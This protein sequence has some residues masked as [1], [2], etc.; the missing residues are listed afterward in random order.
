MILS[1]EDLNAGR[2][3]KFSESFFYPFVVSAAKSR[4]TGRNVIVVVVKIFFL[5][6]W[7]SVELSDVSSVGATESFVCLPVNL[8]HT[9]RCCS[10]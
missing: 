2:E 10:G 6:L 4:W 8:L 9:V 1:R 3:H 7:F 5:M